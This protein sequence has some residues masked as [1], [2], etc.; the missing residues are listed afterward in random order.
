EAMGLGAAAGAASTVTALQSGTAISGPFGVLTAQALLKVVT[1]A[2]TG[3]LGVLLMVFG[4][5]SALKVQGT[6][7][8][9]FAILFGFS[10]Q[11]LTQMVDKQV[12]TLSGLKAP[13]SAAATK[14]Q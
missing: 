6:G 11:L 10:Q 2:L 8:I 9:L 1:G 5:I 7:V 3:W 13:S 14:R 12:G 4:G